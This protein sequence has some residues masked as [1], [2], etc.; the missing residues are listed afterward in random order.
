MK[1]VQQVLSLRIQ[2]ELHV[3]HVLAAVGQEIDSRKIGYCMRRRREM[4]RPEPVRRGRY[5]FT[6]FTQ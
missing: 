1:R 3:A 5:D 6:T 2:I 4:S